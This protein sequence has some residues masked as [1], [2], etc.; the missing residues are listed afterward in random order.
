M[1]LCAVVLV[2]AGLAAYL[3]SLGGVFLFDDEPRIELDATLR[4]LT[5]L[6][7]VL[8]AS[9]LG[10]PLLRL[11]LAVNYAI[12]GLQPRGYHLLNI[13]IHIAAGLTLFGVVRRT[14]LMPRWQHR[15]D[16]A[17]APLALAVALIWLVHPLNSQA[18]TYI[19]QRGESMMGMFYLLTLY[20]SIRMAGAKVQRTRWWFLAGGCCALGMA[21][22]QVM[23]TA[24]LAVM[25]Y[26]FVF[27]TGSWAS[28]WRSRGRLY[29]LLAATWLVLVVAGRVADFFSGGTS[30]GFGYEA[31]G[32]VQYG[33]TQPLV[34]LNYLKLTF[35]PHPLVLDYIF[36]ASHTWYQVD[37]PLVATIKVFGPVVVIAALLAATCWQLVRRTAWGF[38]GGW[39]FL[40]L[41]PSSSIFPIA[42][43]MF[44]HRMYLALAAVVAAVVGG[45]YALGRRRA[46]PR[47][48][49]IVAICV[50]GLVALVLAALTIQ[51]NSEYHSE[52]T[53][54]RTVTQGRP[55][56]PR[57]WYNRGKAADKASQSVAD[58]AARSLLADEA[59]ACWHQ[60]LAR[61]PHYHEA[62][63]NI[64]M[65]LLGRGQLDEAMAHFQRAAEL[66]PREAEYHYNV[67]RVLLARGDW[68]GAEA[69]LLEALALDPDYAKA[70]NNLGAIALKQ[71]NR[72][73]AIER[74]GRAIE[75][76]PDLFEAYMNLAQAL[77]ADERV[78][79]VIRICQLCQEQVAEP[80]E[81][82][83]CAARKAAAL[84]VAGRYGEADRAIDAATRLDPAAGTEHRIAYDQL[85]AAAMAADGRFADAVA[86]QQRAITAAQQA[87]WAPAGIE[88][89]QKRLERYE[90][91]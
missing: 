23:V 6:R 15:F 51:R 71:G 70:T 32:P 73:L 81:Q 53:M 80:S 62:I 13:A 90:R 34:I 68:A 47:R 82:S 27:L 17:A 21:S 40:T 37:A 67:G 20:G 33:L 72:K 52:L 1:R 2:A 41:A 65:V 60:T 42:D 83:R 77:L 8:L 9:D 48:P 19:V 36:K 3:N 26:D 10:R 22:K 16:S 63:N 49:G 57:G 91:R 54:W 74:F 66:G 87:G 79:A 11:T 7:A 58:L 78:E 18:V 25:L 44:E 46:L 24:P 45:S 29:G 31:L 35:W 28:L 84:L 86:S 88:Q 14:L 5:D 61:S 50:T 76:R 64:G 30:A 43:L 69:K 85:R 56:N 89:L 4:D 39:F 75:L 55:D 59:L 38:L 12:D